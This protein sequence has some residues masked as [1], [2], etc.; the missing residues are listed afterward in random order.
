MTR[1]NA[2]LRGETGGD[3]FGLGVL[4]EMGLEMG[5]ADGALER[6]GWHQVV[7]FPVS[8]LEQRPGGDLALL[9]L[10]PLVAAPLGGEYDVA[11]DWALDQPLHPAILLPIGPSLLV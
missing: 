6:A 3:Q 4:G 2:Y 7:V 8:R 10:P 9:Q 11:A 5:V 1:R